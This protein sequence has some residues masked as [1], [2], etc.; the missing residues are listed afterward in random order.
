MGVDGAK[1]LGEG[2]EQAGTG[3]MRAGCSTGLACLLE[4]LLWYVC[5]HFFFLQFVWVISGP[6][7]F[8]GSLLLPQQLQP[9]PT[10]GGH[11]QQLG[12]VCGSLARAW[13][14]TFDVHGGTG[15]PMP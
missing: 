4:N 7:T 12:V 1:K 5:T 14:L 10:A 8:P 11:L 3:Q 2:Y 6:T 15:E 13:P 9:H